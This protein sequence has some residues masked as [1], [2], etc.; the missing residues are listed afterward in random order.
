MMVKRQQSNF[1]DIIY[2]IKQR[3]ASGSTEGR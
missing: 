2:I 1:P 3:E